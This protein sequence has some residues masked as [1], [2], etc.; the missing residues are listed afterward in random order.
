MRP[1]AVSGGCR[2]RVGDSAV[3][4]DAVGVTHD[5]G[6]RLGG[7]ARGHGRAPQEGW[8]GTR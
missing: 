8:E 3:R 4:A 1:I 7:P 2:G 5:D 6:A